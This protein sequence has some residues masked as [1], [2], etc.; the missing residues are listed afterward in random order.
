[1]LVVITSEPS[2]FEDLKINVSEF[3]AFHIVA[4]QDRNTHGKKANLVTVT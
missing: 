3:Y 2:A 1:V 4:R